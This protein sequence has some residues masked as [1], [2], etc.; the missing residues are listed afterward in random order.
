[1]RKVAV[2]TGYI[3]NAVMMGLAEASS[4]QD[5]VRGVRDLTELH[6]VEQIF[7]VL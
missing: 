6:S 4:H 3:N 1:M 5:E 7:V 2:D